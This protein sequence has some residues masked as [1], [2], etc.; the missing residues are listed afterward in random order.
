MKKFLTILAKI[1]CGLIITSILFGISCADS[2]GNFWVWFIIG[3][4]VVGF[5]SRGVFDYAFK[6]EDYVEETW[7]EI[8]RKIAEA[9]NDED[10]L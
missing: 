2:E 1:Y 6:D 5:L 3:G 9:T 8:D 10:D 7:E 4:F